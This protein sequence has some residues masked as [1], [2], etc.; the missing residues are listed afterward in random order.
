MT[1]EQRSLPTVALESTV[2]AHGLPRPVGLETALELEHI[3]RG[4]G[5][6]PRTI[7]IVDGEVVVGLTEQ[8]VRRLASSDSV[9]KASL[10]DL[11][12]VRS[13]RLDAATTG[14]AA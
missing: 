10:R 11:P 6:E 8:Q 3:V 12:I 7:G 2:F 9:R 5:V 13:R 14:R 4:V 1:P